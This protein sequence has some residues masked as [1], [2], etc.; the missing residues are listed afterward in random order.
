MKIET[1]KDLKAVLHLYS[2]D[3]PVRVWNNSAGTVDK[4][5]LQ[6][7][8]DTGHELLIYSKALD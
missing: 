2:D 1:V 4:L 6:E 5:A 8:T 3:M 7:G